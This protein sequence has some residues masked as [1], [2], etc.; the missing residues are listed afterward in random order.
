V[1]V[2]AV[3][4]EPAAIT[5]TCGFTHFLRNVIRDSGKLTFR[6]HNNFALFSKRDLMLSHQLSAAPAILTASEAFPRLTVPNCPELVT[7]EK[8]AA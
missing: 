1:P 4:A 6:I 3:S 7:A 2:G 8:E 5:L